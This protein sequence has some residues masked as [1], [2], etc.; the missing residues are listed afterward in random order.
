MRRIILCIF[1][2]TATIMVGAQEKA[3]YQGYLSVGGGIPVFNTHGT[4]FDV[5]TVHGLNICK[6]TFAGLGFGLIVNSVDPCFP[7]YAKFQQMFNPMSS[8]KPYIAASAGV[9]I[10]EDFFIAPYFSPEV[11]MTINRFSIFAKL[12]MGSFEYGNYLKGDGTT[13]FDEYKLSLLCAGI[14]FRF[15]K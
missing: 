12:M 6:S 5:E 9:L 14:N 10:D 3:Q 1:A 8:A 7:V 11:G 13:V 15:G 2:L 4:S